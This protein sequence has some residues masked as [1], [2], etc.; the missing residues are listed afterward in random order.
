MAGVFPLAFLAALDPA[1]AGAERNSLREQQASS[2]LDGLW[3]APCSDHRKRTLQF[4][5]GELTD[6]VEVFEDEE[7]VRKLGTLVR[8]STFELRGEVI[9]RR[10]ARALRDLDLV[11]RSA[12][13]TPETP[14]Y[15]LAFNSVGECG[16]QD[17]APGSARNILG[18][19]HDCYFL[20]SNSIYPGAPMRMPET[21]DRLLELVRLGEGA[22]SLQVSLD[23]GN[24]THAEKRAAQ[25]SAE[26]F[27][28]E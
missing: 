1:S 2:P 23:F 18:L 25:V 10:G 17:W 4:L 13:W 14:R 8:I 5:A 24:I 27:Q 16:L 11:V 3:S 12:S 6:V 26:K 28:K 20:D 21:G 9:G 7:C 19:R 15:V 22:E